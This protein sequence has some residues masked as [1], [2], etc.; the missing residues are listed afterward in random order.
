MKRKDSRRLGSE[1]GINN[2]KNN[3]WFKDFDWDTPFNNTLN[4]PYI[5]PKGGNFDKK[6]CEAIDNHIEKILERY[7]QYRHKRGFER[8][9]EGYTYINY[10]LTRI[11]SG[12]DVNNTRMTTNSK[13]GKPIISTEKTELIIW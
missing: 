5:S 7:Q 3:V 9:F 4:A 2:L 13:F 8:L 1:G 11:T 6:Y 12:N 10:E